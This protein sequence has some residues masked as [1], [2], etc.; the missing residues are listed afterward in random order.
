MQATL[1]RREYWVSLQTSDRSIALER[2]AHAVE[3]KR[4]Q[5]EHAYRE[6]NK[7]QADDLIRSL[8]PGDA[9]VPDRVGLPQSERLRKYDHLSK[10]ELVGLLEAQDRSRKLGLVWEHDRIGHQAKGDQT[11]PIARL[12]LTLCDKA[13]PWENLI[14]EGDNYDALRWLRLSHRG[15][16]KCI[17]I[18]P[19]YNTGNTDWVYDD[20]YRDPGHRFEQSTWLE[21]LYRRLVLA[22]DLLTDD[23]VI[24]MSI[25]DEQRAVAELVMKEALPDLQHGSLVWRTR[26][27]SN[28]DQGI[29]LSADHEHVLVAGKRGFAFAGNAKSYAAYA[30]PD[31]DPRGDWQAVPMKLSFSHLER[32]NLYYPLHDSK[33]DI[34]YPCNADSV[35]RYATRKRLPR[36]RRLQTQPVE[37]FIAQGRIV[38]PL[39]QRVETFSTLDDLKSA[40][41][42]KDVPLSGGVPILRHDLPDLEFWVGK[43]IGYGT[44]CRKLFKD[45]LQR[46]TQPLSSWITR[47]SD[48]DTSNDGNIQIQAGSYTE[49]TKEVRRLFGSK[50]FNHPKP[51]SLIRELLRQSTSANDL[52]LDFFAG[53]ATTAQAVM[54]LNAEDGGN[55][56]FVMASSTE[57]TNDRPDKNLCRDVT[58]ERV[59]LLNASAEKRHTDLSAAFAYLRIHDL[60]QRH[61]DHALR[62]SDAW[63]SLEALHGLPLTPFDPDSPWNV[64]VGQ[65]MTLVLVNRFDAVLIEWLG[66]QMSKTCYLYAW[67]QGPFEQQFM[68]MGIQVRPIVQALKQAAL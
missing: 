49:G 13:A 18:D 32:P 16:V 34:Y 59:R 35:W 30:N 9:D 51:T 15:R 41:D 1:K 62:P 3:Q 54:E 28:A 50:T 53:S 29:Y 67:D 26:N 68:E 36:G 27:G 4:R 63:T 23:G 40:I 55:R 7:G 45:E 31:F 19:P 2:S 60:D 14:I 47:P 12:D 44:P 42:K 52:I 56:R 48:T 61:L 57:G 25:S 11:V 38:F 6:A 22:R 37:D 43:K 10:A 33:T 5:I 21:F 24:L 65:E 20:R 46:T 58:A 8:L 39:E 66:Q 64:H 17:Y